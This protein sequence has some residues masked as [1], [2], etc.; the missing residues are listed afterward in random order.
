MLNP[1]EERQFEELKK[2]CR[3]LHVMPPPEIM[4]GFQVYDKEGILIFDDVQRGHSWT[5]NFYNRMFGLLVGCLG[6]GTGQFGAGKMSAKQ[7]NG[8][9]YSSNS[10]GYCYNANQSWLF[11]IVVGTG[12]TAFSADD[13]ALAALISD[14]TGSGQLSHQ[15][16]TRGALAYTATP[17]SEKWTLS[18]SR[19]FNN[20]SG[21]SIAVK[22]AGLATNAFTYPFNGAS[23]TA[24]IYNERSVLSPMV[25]VPD[26]G[27]I[28]VT[29]AIS[30]DYSSID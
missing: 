20:N 16:T 2:K 17:G 3:E 4:I 19:M 13:Y 23:I 9:V 1:N 29:Y 15:A 7:V 18:I 10:D 27:R 26:G 6:D 5:R 24:N 12:D 11:D 22:E 28:I 25:V 30:M 21:D 14:G 8:T